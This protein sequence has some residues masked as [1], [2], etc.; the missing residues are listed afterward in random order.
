VTTVLSIIPTLGG[1][2]IMKDGGHMASAKREPIT[3]IW[4]QSPPAGS[5]GRAPGGGSGGEAPWS[6]KHCSLR[7][8]HGN[9]K[10]APFSL[11]CKLNTHMHERPTRHICVFFV[12][13]N[14][15]SN[16]RSSIN[17]KCTVL[18]Q[19]TKSMSEFYH[20]LGHVANVAAKNAEH[21]GR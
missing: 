10:I 21:N 5:R 15:Y 14:N 12:S 6:W 9:G 7:A 20:D 16:V 18:S 8:S 3:E 2:E 1:G 19:S 11:F 13:K 4:G 17:V